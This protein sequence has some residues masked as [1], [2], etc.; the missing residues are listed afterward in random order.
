MQAAFFN[1]HV[2]IITLLHSSHDSFLCRKHEKHFVVAI[3]SNC[4]VYIVAFFV[5]TYLY[6]SHTHLFH[7]FWSNLNLL[8]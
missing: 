3:Y 7:D 8:M 6:L 2:F 5:L 1:L 4:D